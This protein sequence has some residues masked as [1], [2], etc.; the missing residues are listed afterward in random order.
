MCFRL[1]NTIRHCSLLVSSAQ[2]AGLPG[3]C[4]PRNSRDRWFASSLSKSVLTS[5]RAD[6]TAL[7]G[8]RR[9]TSSCEVPNPPLSSCS[10]HP[11]LDLPGGVLPFSRLTPSPGSSLGA[12]RN[13]GLY[14]V[15]PMTWSQ[16]D[17][18]REDLQEI[19]ASNLLQCFCPRPPPRPPKNLKPT[20][21][22]PEGVRAFWRAQ[23]ASGKFKN[24]GSLP[25]PLCLPRG[26]HQGVQ[27]CSV[28]SAPQ[29]SPSSP[30]SPLL[31]GFPYLP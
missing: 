28:P 6:G 8:H 5:G 14:S 19:S 4:S 13:K 30:L 11:P 16:V 26:S 18:R 31:S 27:R 21:R 10:C 1:G 15:S 29:V 22:S 12:I 3:K 2:G 23:A 20:P 9:L 7:S 17:M 24:G 25:G